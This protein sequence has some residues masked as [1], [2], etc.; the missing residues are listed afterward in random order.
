[1]TVRAGTPVRNVTGGRCQSQ[2]A[3][4]STPER[5]EGGHSAHLGRGWTTDR[6]VAQRESQEVNLS[7]HVSEVALFFVGTKRAVCHVVIRCI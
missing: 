6:E 4:R 3:A 2:H 1:M 5:L 7:E